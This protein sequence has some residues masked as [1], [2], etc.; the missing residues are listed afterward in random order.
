MHS[1][2]VPLFGYILEGVLTVDYGDK[3]QRT[4]DEETGFIEAIDWSHNGV[5]Q[6]TAPVRILAVYAGAEGVPNATA[7]ER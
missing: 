2:E 6:T 1:H 5:N 3:G 4:Y 7:D